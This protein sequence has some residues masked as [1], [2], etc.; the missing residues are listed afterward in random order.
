MRKKPALYKE[1]SMKM[2][3]FFFLIFYSYS[4]LSME[5]WKDRAPL[6]PKKDYVAI[7]VLTPPSLPNEIV[8][9]IQS[10]LPVGDSAWCCLVSDYDMSE[11]ERKIITQRLLNGLVQESENYADLKKRIKNLKA[12]K[13]N[14]QGSN[15]VNH[16]LKKAVAIELENELTPYIQTISLRTK[17]GDS[18]LLA[19][20]NTI[21][22]TITQRSRIANF[23]SCCKATNSKYTLHSEFKNDFKNYLMNRSDKELSQWYTELKKY[24]IYLEYCNTITTRD[25][26]IIGGVLASTSIGSVALSVIPPAIMYPSLFEGPYVISLLFSPAI[27]MATIIGG[28]LVCMPGLKNSDRLRCITHQWKKMFKNTAQLIED[29]K[30]NRIV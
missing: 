15:T 25:N 9:H 16:K 2:Y 11:S 8:Q 19:L 24:I 26:L 10:Y 4:L 7:N 18:D 5:R 6:L 27:L 22:T 21:A 1:C 20:L 29:E 13:E 3:M 17:S 23:Q 12:F 14:S 30:K 28:S